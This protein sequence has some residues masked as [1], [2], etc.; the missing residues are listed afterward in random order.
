MPL[1]FSNVLDFTLD[2]IQQVDRRCVYFNICI[3][4]IILYLCM[5]MPV[6]VRKELAG[7]GSLLPQGVLGGIKLRSSASLLT[8]EA[9]LPS[10]FLFKKTLSQAGRM[11]NPGLLRLLTR[12]ALPMVSR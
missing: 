10:V 12:V 3:T 8:A 9:L 1:C 7:V 11:G 5:G 4:F 6:E 2:L